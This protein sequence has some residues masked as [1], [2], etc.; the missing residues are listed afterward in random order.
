[1]AN[2]IWKGHISFGL[3]NVPITLYSA[4]QR[5]DI[6]LHLLDS[7]NAARVR[8][9]R[10]NEVTGAEVP[11]DK[12]VK[13]FEYDGGNYVLL[14][15]E[16]L[17]TAAP[18]L[19]KTI[20]I[21]QFVDLREIGVLYF[22]KPYY[23]VPGK[24]GEKGYVLLREALAE[25]GKVGLARVVIRSRGH[26]AALLPYGKALV[27]E[28]LRFHQE[29]RSLDEYAIPRGELKDYKISRK[30]LEL[31]LQLVEG[32]SGRWEPERFHDEY[33]EALMKHIEKRI[34]VGDTQGVG[35]PEAP[36]AE[37]PSTVN[38]M[39]MLKKSLEQTASAGKPRRTTVR[40]RKST[41]KR[42]S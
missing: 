39:S 14:S 30:E 24:G 22:D 32:L 36:V 7:R 10:I 34:A 2:P 13:G 11:W 4:E 1:M 35:E 27:L 28:L 15:D 31:A 26:L 6:S 20:P 33:R 9:E 16:E 21:E 19:T 29:L 37:A 18:E 8:Y 40:T 17:R 3:V 38:F 23:L 12:V 41:R 5:T 42:A 25:S